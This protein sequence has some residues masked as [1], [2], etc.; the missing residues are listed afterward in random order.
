MKN[1]SIS[2]ATVVLLALLALLVPPAAQPQ[3]HYNITDIGTLG[4]TY[5]QA[6]GLNNSG[7]VVGFASPLGD[8]AVHA[9]VWRKGVRTDLGTLGGPISAVS[10]DYPL[11]DHGT[12][13]G[14]SN[15][16]TPD[17]NGEDF[18]GIQFTLICL[19]FVW[20]DGVLTPLPLLGGNN[21]DAS[22]INNRG[23]IVGSAETPTPDPTCAFAFLQ[24]EAVLWENGHVQEL[25]P[26]PGDPV[27]NAI[28]INDNG[29]VVGA[30]GCV[31]GNVH[32]VLWQNGTPI[33]L[34]NLGSESFNLAFAI[35]NRGQVVG[36]STLQDGTFHAFLWQNGV[37][38]DLGYLPG[39]PVSLAN[40]IN[41]KGQVVGI[42]F[43]GGDSSAVA[44]VW[45]NGK[46]ADLN[47]LIPVN[48]P[49]FLLEALG[50]N[51]RGEIAGFMFNTSN[52]EV[53]GYLLTPIRGSENNA[54]AARTNA[55]SRAPVALPE[56]VRQVLRRRMN[57]RDRWLRLRAPTY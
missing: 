15:I 12:V 49:W 29:Q 20:Q 42:S 16:S 50:V 25:P 53:H 14:F 47:T 33:D 39:L 11:N 45:Q 48:S 21:G 32:A 40:G 44:F 54:P 9:F 22:S 18:C 1:P 34:G 24:N 4:G 41:N 2:V 27:G 57:V 52:G 46:M 19:P 51:D 31:N 56:N 10:E 26:L 8:Q 17:P 37:M 43:S 13:A 5:S 38:A 23:Q 36:Q 28:E 35:N 30:T 3:T 55:T 6:N 7:S